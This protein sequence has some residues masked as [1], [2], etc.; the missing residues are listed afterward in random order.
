MKQI[1]SS[2]LV[3]SI[4]LSLGLNACHQQQSIGNQ[5]KTVMSN[6]LAKQRS[7]GPLIGHTG[8]YF[9]VTEGDCSRRVTSDCMDSTV[10]HLNSDNLCKFLEK[11][12][13]RATKMSDGNY[14]LRAH[15]Y[16]K[17]GGATGFWVGFLTG[18]ILTHVVVYTVAGV[19]GVVTA[20]FTG[21][22]V[23]AAIAGG[24]IAGSA[25]ATEFASNIIGSTVGMASAVVT[26]PV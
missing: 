9:A 2:A 19:V 10:K 25:P 3:I 12:S 13:V 23:A 15:I 20:P 6:R 4:I 26:G 7:S 16:G 18:K 8:K 22:T 14:M 24:I 21:G 1:K 17:G 5:V 11:G